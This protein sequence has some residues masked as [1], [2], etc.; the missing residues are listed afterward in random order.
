MSCSDGLLLL[1]QHA[2][3]AFGGASPITH[4]SCATERPELRACSI[5]SLGTW[6]HRLGCLT[7]GVLQGWEELSGPPVSGGDGVP[8]GYAC[9]HTH[10]LPCTWQS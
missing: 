6:A 2:V 7:E 5:R 4:S 9:A 10:H 1:S 3:P 8:R